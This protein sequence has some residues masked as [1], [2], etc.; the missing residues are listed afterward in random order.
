MDVTVTTPVAT[1]ATSA[2][3]D[4][5][6]QATPTVTGVSPT[7][8]PTAGGTT[9]A[10]AGTGFSGATGVYF[11]LSAASSYTVN[12]PTSIT[13][14]APAGSAGTV[15]VTVTTPGGTSATSAAD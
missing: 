2:S 1:S 12:S 6:Y 4:F 14:T 3:D 11:G 5:T 7:A 13:A 15:D 8:G 9:V 10:I